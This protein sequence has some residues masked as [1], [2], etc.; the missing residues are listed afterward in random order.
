MKKLYYHLTAVVV[1]AIF[2]LEKRE[3]KKINFKVSSQ[4]PFW[5]HLA[6]HFNL[7]SLISLES[8]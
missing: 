8:F 2:W 1:T 5:E 7:N 6:N 4:S 3:N